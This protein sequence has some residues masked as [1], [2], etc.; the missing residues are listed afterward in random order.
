MVQKGNCIGV[1]FF[2]SWEE[3]QEAEE[4]LGFSKELSVLWVLRMEDSIISRLP[5]SGIQPGTA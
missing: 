2:C 3:I 4:M 1:Y 5:G